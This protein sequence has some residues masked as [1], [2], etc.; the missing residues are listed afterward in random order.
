MTGAGQP[1]TGV[2][3]ETR[4][5]LRFVL[6]AD[7]GAGPQHSLQRAINV[8]T[9]EVAHAVRVD[10]AQAGPQQH[11]R[12]VSRLVYGERDEPYAVLSRLG[13]RLEAT[14]APTAVLPTIVETVAQALRSPHVALDV[15]TEAGFRTVAEYPPS[16]P[17]AGGLSGRP[18]FEPSTA[19]LRKLAKALKGRVP[20]VGVGGILSGADARAKIEA[21]ASLVQLYTGLIYRGPGLVGECVSAYRAK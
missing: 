8:V 7:S 5:V 6:G 19:I 10:A 14:L 16:L 13:Q 4:R 18:L 1:E 9:F 2:A 11:V 17:Q 3:I 20:L 15:T 12:G 21:G